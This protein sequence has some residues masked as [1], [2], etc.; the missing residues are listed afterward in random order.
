MMDDD[1]DDDSFDDYVYDAAAGDEEEDIRITKTSL[2][3][4][5]YPGHIFCQY[6]NFVTF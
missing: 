1:D 3:L 4:Q 6:I 5:T 2:I